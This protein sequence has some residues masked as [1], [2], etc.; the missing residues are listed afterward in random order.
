MPFNISIFFNLNQ[1][2]FEGQ[3]EKVCRER[4]SLSGRKYPV[5]LPLFMTQ[6]S[7]FLKK[8]F[9]PMNKSGTKLECSEVENDEGVLNRVK[10]FLKVCRE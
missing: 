1:K 7:A 3:N 2:D 8:R 6:L 9:N 10:C 4:V 5:D